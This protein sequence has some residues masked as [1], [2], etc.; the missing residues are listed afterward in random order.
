MMPPLVIFIQIMDL[1]LYGDGVGTALRPSLNS[2]QRYAR[3]TISKRYTYMH[4]SPET[5]YA[6][7]SLDP[8]GS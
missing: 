4:I 2:Y 5:K 6:S 1:N 7:T 3:S 8:D